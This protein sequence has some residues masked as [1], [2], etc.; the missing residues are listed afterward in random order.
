MEKTAIIV[1]ANVILSA[2]INPRG[3]T[4]RKLLA[5]ILDPG[6]TL[7]TPKYLVEEIDPKIEEIAARKGLKSAEL[8]NAINLLLAIFNTVED[9]E[10]RNHIEH[11]LEL[12]NDPKDAPYVA[13]ALHLKEKHRQV[14][15]LTY[16]TNDY[17][18]KE[19]VKVGIRVATPREI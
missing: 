16:N 12:V 4:H 5:L 17:K 19:L 7:Y 11:A 15:I 2:A 14:T 3:L 13:L 18:K 8:R 1:D 9:E 10:Y 6:I